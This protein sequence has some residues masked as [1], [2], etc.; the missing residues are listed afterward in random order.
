LIPCKQVLRLGFLGLEDLYRT[1]VDRPINSFIASTF[2]NKAE[3]LTFK[4]AYRQSG[5]STVKQ[6]YSDNLIKDPK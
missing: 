5:K 1:T 6:A 4:E 3:S 2:G